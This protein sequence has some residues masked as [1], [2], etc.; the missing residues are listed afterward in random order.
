MKFISIKIIH[1][2]QHNKKEKQHLYEKLKIINSHNG[3]IILE[4]IVESREITNWDVLKRFL[5]TFP[6]FLILIFSVTIVIYYEDVKNEQDILEHEEQ[7]HLELADVTIFSNFQYT[8]KDLSAISEKQEI[9]RF[10]DGNESDKENLEVLFQHFLEVNANYDQ[11]R[12]LNETG[13]EVIK[14]KN[15]NEDT[16]IVPENQLK[17]RGNRNYF[18]E[19]IQHKKDEVYV[20]PF[21]LNIENEEIEIP[22]NPV[23]YF[24]TPIFDNYNQ[25]RG[26]IV[27]N[28]LGSEIL[29][30]F[31]RITQYFGDAHYSLL[32]SNGYYLKGVNREDEWGCMFENGTNRTFRKDNPELWQ[33]ILKRKTGHFLTD[34]GLFSFSTIYPLSNLIISNSTSLYSDGL[35]YSNNRSIVRLEYF[36][37]IVSFISD[38]NIYDGP[39]KTL[40]DLLMIDSLLIVILAITLWT[41][42]N[43]QFKKGHAEE[44]LQR[45]HDHLETIV[46]E[47]TRELMESEEKFRSI[48]ASA[49]EAIIMMDDKS[50]IVYWNEAAEKIF[51]HSTEEAYG[52]EV[53]T[54]IAPEKYLGDF[55]RSFPGFLESGGAPAVGK[56]L[57]L[58]GVRK[59]GTEFPIELSVSS[60]NHKGVW[61][62]V[63]IIRD[64]T[65]RRKMEETR[66]QYVKKLHVLH[67][68]FKTLVTNSPD[69][70]LIVDKKGMIIFVNPSGE[71]LLG[72][73]SEN[74]IGSSFEF[75]QVE[76]E[77]MEMEILSESGQPGTVEMRFVEIEWE[78]EDVHL[79]MLHNITDRKMMEEE[80]AKLA[81]MKSDFIILNAHELGTPLMVINGYLEELKDYSDLYGEDG[82]DA[83]QHIEM[84]L[85]RIQTLQKA[86]YNIT[87][88]E[89]N[90]F[91]LN[92]KPIFV[93]HI[94]K[95]VLNELSIVAKQKQI[96]F[97][98]SYPDYNTILA[99]GDRIHKVISILVENAIKYT[100]EGGM[101]EVSGSNSDPDIELI[102]KDN[103]IGIS[104]ADQEN[105]FNEFYQA[106]DI[107]GH[108]DGFGL[109]LCLAKGI[110]ES[111]GG[112]IRVESI[113][114]KGSSFHIRLPR[115]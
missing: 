61:N 94:T 60:I 59:D 78:G 84:N 36:W 44:E 34:K 67:N 99:D 66:E 7:H 88:L 89:R 4:K 87:L 58:E 20:S 98:S 74:L 27:I 22:I 50:K 13:M 46:E 26:V 64:I 14:I 80:R 103:G 65:E 81:S 63:A 95:N 42:S 83:I 97:V 69:G 28:Y 15:G 82:R 29:N 104:L 71:S 3:L 45:Q 79:V 19:V 40:N 5:K 24:G 101:I 23:I 105:I 102:V 91:T 1:E 37:I 107:M 31:E 72:K 85:K 54:F 75:P 8:I 111:H 115:G 106:E 52:R 12:L 53:H 112:E 11:I 86:M 21:E 16:F 70:I 110:I 32:N 2:N 68:R 6:L 38:E 57:E 93:H 108:K 62:A 114:G 18:Q 55:S 41:L 90:K 49:N 113:P 51:G 47:R 10:L 77:R 100:P 96:S 73:K 76:D 39:Q 92:K 48:S 17:Y 35:N 9:I 33:Q 30:Q 25:S 56:T 109:G 43:T